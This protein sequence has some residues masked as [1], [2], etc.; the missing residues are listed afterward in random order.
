MLRLEGV[1]P[2]C[3]RS[4]GLE[5]TGTRNPR[6]ALA[7]LDFYPKTGRLVLAELDATLGEEAEKTS[8]QALLEALRS[9]SS[10]FEVTGLSIHAP[11]SLPPW[12]KH[13]SL[14][15]EETRWM[16]SLWT[17]LKPQP[18]PFL[19]YLQRP[20]EVWLRH[21]TSERFQIPDGLGSNGAPLAARVQFLLKSLP[22]PLNESYPRATITRLVHSLELSPKWALLYTDLE[23]GVE[24][25]DAFLTNLCRKLP[26]IFIYE[27]DYETLVME[28]QAFQAFLSALNQHLLF[29]KQTENRPEGF[30]K[31]AAWIAIPR[32]SV[33]W[34]K[35]F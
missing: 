1:K 33:L 23:R 16:E 6:T 9:Y 31:E 25:R 24:T 4:L 28:L 32:R 11:T 19:P 3:H 35:V 20:V 30:P 5:L 21:C 12:F 26:Q 10:D 8:D 15:N 22:G 13:G 17:K 34:D 7:A 2:D 29:R 18:K 14:E 27:K